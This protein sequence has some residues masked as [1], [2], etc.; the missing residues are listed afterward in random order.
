MSQESYLQIKK[1]VSSSSAFGDFSIYYF[2][3]T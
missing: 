2:R 3:H 1:R